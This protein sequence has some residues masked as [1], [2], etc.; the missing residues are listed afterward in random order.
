MSETVNPEKPALASDLILP[1]IARVLRAGE[2]A[3]LVTL[4]D[5]PA[6]PSQSGAKLLVKN[7]SEHWGSLGQRAAAAGCE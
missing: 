5:A 4:I 3:A 6:S 2:I 1:E 7:S